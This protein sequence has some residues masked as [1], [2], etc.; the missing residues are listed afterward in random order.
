MNTWY[1]LSISA[2]LCFGCERFLYKVSAARNL[3]TAWT[4]FA[5]MASVTCISAGLFF[6]LGARVSGISFLMLVALANSISFFVSTVSQIEAL[7][8]VPTSI[9]YPVIRLNTVIV[10]AFSLFY[11]K[12][13]LSFSQ[14]LGI[15]LSIIVM[16][17]M[18]RQ[19]YEQKGSTGNRK[20]GLMLV[21][22]AMF[23]GAV[24]AIS[25]K[26]AALH[27]NTL[28]FIALSYAMGSLF[29]F[30]SRKRF[31]I[32]ET[33]SNIKES[34]LLG[35][36]IGLINLAG[37]Y[38]FLRALVSG[39]LSIVISITSMHFVVAIAL[40]ALIY[41]EKISLARFA[42]ICLSVAAIIL[43]RL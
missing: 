43:M 13:P 19:L 9:V 33:S 38:L 4:T 20:A 10:V 32:D 35:F 14:G 15:I 36:F 16:V 37:F 11:F 39:P 41:R 31:R 5:F 17:F 1:I 6:M 23:A 42:L 18:T 21:M 26:F 40:A 12:D 2:L 8:H 25:S 7:K 24:A 34:L 30:A 27:T 29:S 22:I 3:S 28:A